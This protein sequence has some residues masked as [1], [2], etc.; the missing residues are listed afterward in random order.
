MLGR[1]DEALAEVRRAIEMSEN[2]QR[3]Q[4][5]L[6]LANAYCWLGD[7]E[8]ALNQLD[9][10]VSENAIGVNYGDLKFN[11]AWDP[12]REDPRFEKFSPPQPKRFR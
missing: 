1:K 5:A 8:R 2:V 3:N 4:F 10:L 11:P 9:K 12:L 6:D 7:P